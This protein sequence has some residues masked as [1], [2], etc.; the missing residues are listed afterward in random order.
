MIFHP[1]LAAKVLSGEKTVTRRVMKTDAM[2]LVPCRYKVNK[3]YAVQPGRG[4]PS[5][6]RLHVLDVSSTPLLPMTLEE[7]NREGFAYIADLMHRWQT[8]G[9]ALHDRVW[10]IEFELVPFFS[11][12]ADPVGLQETTAGLVK[13]R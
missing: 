4:K 11:A 9:G 5:I 8:M 2:G 1:D 12:T 6:G 7:A 3:T 10:R 13:P